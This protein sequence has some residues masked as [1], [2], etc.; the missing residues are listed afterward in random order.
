M[1]I[2]INLSLTARFLLTLIILHVLG[3]IVWG[4]DPDKKINQ[5]PTDNW[6][7]NDGLPSDAIL[8][9]NQTGDGYLWVSTSNG[10]VRF[11]GEQ[12]TPFGIALIHTLPAT[13]IANSLLVDRSKNTIWIGHSDSLLSFNFE[14]GQ[15][16]N[17]NKTNGLT[18]KK[19]RRLMLD[20]NGNLWITFMAGGLKR[21]GPDG[22]VQQFNLAQLE[23]KKINSI[24][25]DQ[26]GN[27]FLATIGDGVFLY[28]NNDTSASWYQI[29]G[30]GK[31]FIVNLYQDQRERLW[32]GTKNGLYI[33]D[34]EKTQHFTIKHGLVGNHIA[35]IYEDSDSNLWIPAISGGLSRVTI[36]K[37]GNVSLESELR[38]Y[39]IISIF[40]DR[41]KNLWLG[42]LK[43]GLIRLKDRK[44]S[45]YTPIEEYHEELL[46]A[47]FE[48][49]IQNIW[50]STYNGSLFHIRDGI[51]H[52]TPTSPKLTGIPINA[53]A[54]DKTGN[55]WLGTT[56]KGVFNKTKN[57]FLHITKKE[58]LADNDVTSIFCSKSG[59]MWFATANGVSVYNHS[60][61]T[62]QS[63][64]QHDGLSGKNAYNFFE[65]Q[66]GNIWVAADQGV[67]VLKDGKMDQDH[68][69][70]YLEGVSVSSIHEDLTA[71]A[72][73]G[74]VFWLATQT[75]GIKR[76]SIR[77]KNIVS[78]TTAHGMVT[79]TIYQLHLDN[80][81][82]FWL[83][84]GKGLL[85]LNRS[86]LNRFTL[87]NLAKINCISYDETDG[88]KSAEFNNRFSRHSAIQTA[89]G[90]LWFITKKGI[91][92]VNPSEIVINK[93]PPPVVIE[94]IIINQKVH[95]LPQ[96]GNI[97]VPAGTKEI[98]FRFTAP[99]FRSPEKVRFKCQ[100]E[101]Y[102][103]GERLLLPGSERAVEYRGLAPG[104]YT[105][106]LKACNSDGIWNPT[107]AS[108]AFSIAP[109]FYQTL[110]FKIVIMLVLLGFGVIA[111]YTFKNYNQRIREK[112]EKE[113]Q[114]RK[115]PKPL[116]HPDFAE[117]QIKR[118]KYLMEEKKVYRDGK[119]TL[120]K[121]AKKLSIRHDQLSRILNEHLNSNFP[122]YINH[123]R[124]EDAKNILSS[125]KG[126]QKKIDMLAFEVGFNAATTFNKVF[127]KYTGKSPG[128]YRR[129]VSQKE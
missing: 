116:L 58:N 6:Q 69:M 109:Y 20:M 54:E 42:T 7:K 12:F 45:S 26:H 29:D 74:P 84:S 57:G 38:E 129:E 113:K 78:F 51:L 11:D 86:E 36:D 22:K 27:L 17:Y 47:V 52:K 59:K 70:R 117:E 9:I 115:T 103:N 125:P 126:T 35:D 119:I 23:D 55:L 14:T 110:F 94:K 89:N 62:I 53:I 102:E 5:Y 118:I 91:V 33:F 82:I 31:E 67:T 46:T 76:L 50:I 104:T 43:N 32:I 114:K 87:K 83:S 21:V 56:G 90:E 15:T 100:L 101:G 4:L 88:M 3:V 95:P 107:G 30:L 98:S 97:T 49:R 64:T 99:T 71:P 85:R 37:S 41:E 127:K 120:P 19:I 60:D 79:N 72:N 34:G 40:E 13:I 92:T 24:L 8:A 128:Q 96:K 2:Q 111:F 75:Q 121:L 65:D 18:G 108:L 48:D 44:F 112:I 63:F 73:E 66:N 61:G 1:N 81:N 80:T 25:E 68:V 123:F 16:H 122:E 10:L 28:K 39:S 124:I 106:K 93:K 77:S 105:F